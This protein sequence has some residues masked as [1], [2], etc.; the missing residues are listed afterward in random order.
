VIS[1]PESDKVWK[2]EFKEKKK[3]I[4]LREKKEIKVEGEREGGF[5]ILN[6]YFILFIKLNYLLFCTIIRK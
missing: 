4:F 1:H 5:T 3:R 2:K 6:K